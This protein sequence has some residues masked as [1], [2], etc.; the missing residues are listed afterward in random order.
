MQMT[1]LPF[2]PGRNCA[3]TVPEAPPLVRLPDAAYHGRIMERPTRIT[4]TASAKT[5]RMARRSNGRF[6]EGP[7]FAGEGSAPV[8]HAFLSNARD[9]NAHLWASPPSQLRSAALALSDGLFSQTSTVVTADFDRLA[10]DDLGWSLLNQDGNR[11]RRIARR[12]RAPRNG[13]GAHR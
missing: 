8:I 2:D 5:T 9:A 7:S 13:R 4:A 6:V 12:R 11:G 10:L 1:M 3:L